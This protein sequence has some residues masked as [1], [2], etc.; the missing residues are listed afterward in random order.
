ML[1]L[2]VVLLSG[3]ALGS[4]SAYFYTFLR[5]VVCLS[6]VRLLHSC[7]LLKPFDGFRCHLAGILAGSKDTLTAREG[8]IWVEPQAKTCS[9]KLQRNCQSYAG[10]WRIQTK[11]DSAFR[12]TTLVLT[13][14]NVSWTEIDSCGVGS[15]SAVDVCHVTSL[16]VT[17]S[18]RWWCATTSAR[19]MY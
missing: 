13:G 10:T 8:E 17:W 7:T 11:S 14:S 16:I 12:Q 4:D 3:I 15:A 9:C 1:S 18:H 2:I 19:W 6:V 5:S